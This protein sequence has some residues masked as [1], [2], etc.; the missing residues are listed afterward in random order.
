MANQNELN[1]LN[2]NG[3]F[4][5]KK[6][7]TCKPFNPNDPI[8]SHIPA[9]PVADGEIIQANFCCKSTVKFLQQPH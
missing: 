9:F 4:L 8:K 6:L 2:E 1:L 5:F 3:Q 7:K